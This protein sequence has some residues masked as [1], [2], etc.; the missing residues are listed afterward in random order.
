[1]NSF[2]ADKVM[3]QVLTLGML[4]DTVSCTLRTTPHK[5]TLQKRG[6]HGNSFSKNLTPYHRRVSPNHPSLS[7]YVLNYTFEKKS[8]P[9]TTIFTLFASKLEQAGVLI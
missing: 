5:G 8:V 9:F 3:C 6:Q 2:S 4:A 1:M 7:N